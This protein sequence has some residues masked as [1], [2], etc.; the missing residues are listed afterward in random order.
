MLLATK[1]VGILLYYITPTRKGIPMIQ[2]QNQK[3]LDTIPLYKHKFIIP[4]HHG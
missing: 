3:M 2:I 1:A 4:L